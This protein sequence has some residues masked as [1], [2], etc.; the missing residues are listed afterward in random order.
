MSLEMEVNDMIKQAMLAKDQT[1]LRGLRAIKSALLLAKTEKGA[2]KEISQEKELQIIQQLIKQ[3]KDS[4]AIFEQQ[5]RLDLAQKEKEEI[6]VIEHFL[7]EQLS[8]EQIS[9]IVERIIQDT[10]SSS[11]KD[12]GRVMGIASKQLA[13][14]VDNKTLADTVKTLL[15]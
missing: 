5:N 8:R 9:E 11:I 12:M 6:G 1:R 10:E 2:S 14:K 13:G 15:S 3:R 4:I 7:P